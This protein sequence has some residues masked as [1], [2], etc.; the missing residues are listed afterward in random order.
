M[1]WG[2][3][4]V[5]NYR[6]APVPRVLGLFALAVGTAGGAALLSRCDHPSAGGAALVGSAAVFGAGLMDDLAPIGPRGLRNHL[7]ALAAGRVTT[8]ALKLVVTVASAVVVIAAWGRGGGATRIAGVVLVAGA[9]NVWNGLDVRPGRALKAYALVGLATIGVDRCLL[10]SALPVVLVAVPA[11]LGW[12]LRERAM[13]GDAGA[14]FLGF[15]GGLA[16]YGTLPATGVWLGAALAVALN[17]LA[18]TVTLSRIIEIMPPLRWIDRTGRA[19][20]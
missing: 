14:T 4:A 17:V 5:Q 13:L 12:D 1:R 20:E 7:A 15:T 9:T 8:G 18:D 16:L 2:R 3:L 11:A 10:P 6:G 19:R